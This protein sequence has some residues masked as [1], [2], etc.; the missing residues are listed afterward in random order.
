[1]IM[2]DVLNQGPEKPRAPASS[3]AFAVVRRT[4][5]GLVLAYVAVIMFLMLPMIQT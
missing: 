5:V 2:K 3:H 1:M 4:A